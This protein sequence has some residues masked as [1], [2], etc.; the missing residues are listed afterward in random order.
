MLEVLNCAPLT[1]IQDLGRPGLRHLGIASAGALDPITVQQ[2]NL[3]L[4][5]DPK[6]AVIELT[7]GRGMFQ[8]HQDAVFAFS[9][10]DPG[11]R[12]LDRERHPLAGDPLLPGHACSVRAGEILHL[13]GPRVAGPSYL[14]IA[15]GFQVPV[16][17]GSRS[18]DLINRFGGLHGR[19][20]Q[21]GDCIAIGESD[22]NPAIR[23]GIRPPA[24]DG[25]LRAIQGPEYSLFRAQ[26]R[27]DLWQ[28]GWRVDRDS[29]RMGLRLRGGRLLR[30]DS[31]EIPSS[32]VLPGVIQV[33]ADGRPI[34]LG[35]DA[36]TMGGYPRIATI[37]RADL[38]QL[39]Y[40]PPGSE[41]QLLEVSVDEAR[42]L[43]REEG[44]YLQRLATT[45]DTEARVEA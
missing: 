33:P 19:P 27:A 45:L 22:T 20:L 11:A 24:P 41:V 39:A 38:W 17:L 21:S 40:L 44:E 34:I 5:N 4:G 26:S 32:P 1:S 3:L 25:T 9:G 13:S 43:A 36:Q 12:L 16:V 14:A 35:N 30:Q 8:F 31:S 23:S 42:A 28:E 6:A 18:T 7:T 15:G 37:I 10:I 29:S 2:L